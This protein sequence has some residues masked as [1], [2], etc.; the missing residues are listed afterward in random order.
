MTTVDQGPADVS[1]NALG[2]IGS[3]WGIILFLGI[4]SVIVG[5]IAL[6]WPG[7]TVLVIAILLAIWLIVSGI[8]EIVRGFS[9]GLSGGMRALLFIT[10]IL[11]VILGII[12]FRSMFQAVEILA[13]FVGIMFLFRGFGALF[14]GAEQK[15]G[16]GWNI[17]G[18]IVMLIGGLV[19]LVWPAIS[20]VT[21]AWVAGIWLI[22]GGIFEIVAAFRVRSAVKAA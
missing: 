18:G 8:F 3:H 5:I 1:D 14:M 16:R 12:A 9:R 7:A 17:F 11:S 15:E 10:G 6:V 21:L 22:V 19:I 20:L 2:S 4:T 13:I